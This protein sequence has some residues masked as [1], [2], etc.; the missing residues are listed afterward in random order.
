[1]LRTKVRLSF[2]V[3]SRS[4]CTRPLVLYLQTVRLGRGTVHL[5]NLDVLS[6]MFKKGLRLDLDH[7]ALR[8]KQHHDF[9][10]CCR[11]V[12]AKL[13]GTN[14]YPPCFVRFPDHD[15]DSASKNA[16]SAWGKIYSKT[17]D[18]RR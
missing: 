18:T 4:L 6:T 8:S 1:M 2:G 5:S 15:L 17:T 13:V 12:P 14:G 16:P 9:V 3:N 7:A 10:T 11:G